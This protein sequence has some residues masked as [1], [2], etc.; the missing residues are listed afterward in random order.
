MVIPKSTKFVGNLEWMFKE[1]EKK[2]GGAVKTSVFLDFLFHS[3]MVYVFKY[4]YPVSW[5][6][7]FIKD[8]KKKP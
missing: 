5:I 3:L 1:L 6:K 8:Q 7:N 4:L 2:G